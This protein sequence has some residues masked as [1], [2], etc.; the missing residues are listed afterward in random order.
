MFFFPIGGGG[1]HTAPANP[2]VL[3]TQGG[4]QW[5]PI[6]PDPHHPLTQWESRPQPSFPYT[7]TK[8]HH[9]CQPAWLEGSPTFDRISLGVEMLPVCE[10]CIGLVHFIR[11]ECEGFDPPTFPIN[12]LI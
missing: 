6:G 4:I 3:A 2:L 10:P 11:T 12:C 5:L 1:Q 7:P 8:R 9:R